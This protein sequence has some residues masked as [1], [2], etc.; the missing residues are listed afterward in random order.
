MRKREDET[1]AKSGGKPL[2]F[3]ENS[4]EFKDLGTLH[5]ERRVQAYFSSDDAVHKRA[6]SQ[7]TPASVPRKWKQK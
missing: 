6:Q 2:N 5:Q 3:H 1:Q 7:I 4:E